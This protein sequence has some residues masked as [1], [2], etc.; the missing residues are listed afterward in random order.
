MLKVKKYGTGRQP[1]VL[2]HGWGMN[3][4]VWE[5]LLEDLSPYYQ[6]TAIDLPGFGVNS[7]V[8]PQEYL[9]PDIAQM[10]VAV[11]PPKAI[12]AGWSLGGLVATWIALHHPQYVEKL[13]LIASTPC[14]LQRDEWKGIKPEVL[15][16]FSQLLLSDT[17]KTIERFLAI[18]AMGSATGKQDVRQIRQT[19]FQYDSPHETALSGGLSILE[20]IDLR[21]Q[22]HQLSMPVTGVY[23]RLDSLVPKHVPDSLATVIPDFRFEIIDKASHAPFVSHTNEF[24]TLFN[25]LNLDE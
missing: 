10:I 13:S 2:L 17:T 11:C 14:F 9:L 21:D 24:V 25:Q 1:L 16:G 3:S 15:A 12:I 7:D 19:I 20:N 6:I 22:L 23:G 18:Q 8:L 5:H 4:G